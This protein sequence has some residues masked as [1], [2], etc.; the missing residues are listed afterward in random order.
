M[1]DKSDYPGSWRL[2]AGIVFTIAFL[3]MV[4]VSSQQIDFYYFEEG[5]WGERDDETGEYPL[6]TRSE[7]CDRENQAILDAKGPVRPSYTQVIPCNGW[8]FDTQVS[9]VL[10]L[11]PLGFAMMCLGRPYAKD[12]DIALKSEKEFEEE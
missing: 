9:I 1:A 10:T 12:L 6:E 3:L 8:E 2:F 11:L 5:N 7:Y 4:N